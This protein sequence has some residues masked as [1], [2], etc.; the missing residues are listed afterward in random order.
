MLLTNKFSFNNKLTLTSS[1]PRA[2]SVSLEVRGG[3]F[4]ENRGDVS[5][6]KIKDLLQ[7]RSE[8]GKE[9][10]YSHPSTGTNAFLRTSTPEY[11]YSH[12]S[13]S[14]PAFMCTTTPEYQYSHNH[15]YISQHILTHLYQFAA[16]IT[17]VQ[18][19][20]QRHDQHTSTPL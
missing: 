17:G 16:V 8:I 9:Y 4:L 2:A 20:Q 13:T 12:P 5:H 3:N 6:P 18:V 19:R 14:T 1:S 7:R 15:A 10:Q 11:Q